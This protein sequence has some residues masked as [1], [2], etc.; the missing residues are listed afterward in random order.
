MFSIKIKD[1]RKN[2][3]SIAHFYRSIDV[4]PLFDPAI[5][6]APASTPLYTSTA[7][8]LFLGGHGTVKLTASLHR[9]TWI[10]GQRC[11]VRIFVANDSEKRKVQSL[12]LTLIRSE[13]IFKPNS[14]AAVQSPTGTR[15][16]DDLDACTTSTFK[17]I[18]AKSI[19]EMGE[20]VTAKH[21]TAKGWWTGVEPGTSQEF[22]HF[23]LLPVGRPFH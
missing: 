1:T 18:V 2:S 3:R 12:S 11:Y 13:T 4:W 8:S 23:I 17:R 14:D 9:P 6:L 10:A 22:N 16:H 15:I 7:K 21:A 20:K 19:L 5:V